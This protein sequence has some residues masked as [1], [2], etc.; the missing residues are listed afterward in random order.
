MKNKNVND[1]KELYKIAK[2]HKDNHKSCGGEPYKSYNKLFEVKLNFLNKKNLDQVNDVKILEIG[3]AVGFTTFVLHSAITPVPYGGETEGSKIDTIEFHQEHIDEAKRNITE[4]GGDVS[5]IN[6]LQGDAKDILKNLRV[7]DYD[8]I[9]FDGYGAKMDFY[10]EF[11]RILKKNGLLI[12]ANKYLKSTEK[13]YFEN[14]QNKEVWE[15]I[16]NFDDTEVHMKV[17]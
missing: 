2:L 11:K 10:N 5:K 8:L 16:E 17:C 3:T 4:W 9:F 6:F 1:L 14:L 13:E 12:T 15:F 7:C